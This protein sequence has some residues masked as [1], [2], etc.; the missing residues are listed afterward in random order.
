MSDYFAQFPTLNY[1]GNVVRNIMLRVK[2]LEGVENDPY[3]Y[4]P[5]TV[6]EGERPEDIAYYYY[7]SVEY[8]WL[9]F[10]SNK[11]IDPYFEWPLSESDLFASI[12]KKYR[13]RALADMNKT[14]MSDMEIFH[15]SMNETRTKNIAFYEKDGL[16]MS[17]DSY[18]LADITL[19][20]WQPVRIFD[21]EN[22]RNESM[23]NIQLLNSTYVK[24]A[25]K[26]LKE[27]LKDG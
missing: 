15:W 25:D 8:L 11:V 9:V 13:D 5:Y 7:G 22:R 3:A 1:K 27:L 20:G 2:I 18:A 4:L 16:R 23:R 19:D 10:L 21:D 26:N 24:T 12:A 17:P 14:Y 6:K